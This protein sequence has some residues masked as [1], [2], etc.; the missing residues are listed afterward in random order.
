[1]QNQ[2]GRIQ[3]SSKKVLQNHKCFYIENLVNTSVAEIIKYQTHGWSNHFLSVESI[4]IEKEKAA[5]HIK[6]F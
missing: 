6:L 1:M 3:N 5:C 4:K 2:I